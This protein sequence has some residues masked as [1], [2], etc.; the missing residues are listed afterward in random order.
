MS[1]AFAIMTS[2]FAEVS[3]GV[4]LLVN[5]NKTFVLIGDNFCGGVQLGFSLDFVQNGAGTG[6][7]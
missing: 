3:G 7:E 5:Q 4:V 6:D 2:G 1:L